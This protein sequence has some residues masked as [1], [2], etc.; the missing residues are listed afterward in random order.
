MHGSGPN[1]F[2]VFAMFAVFCWAFRG[3]RFHRRGFDEGFGGRPPQ[4]VAKQIEVA[5][6]ERDAT[7]ADLE[8]RVRVLERIATDRKSRLNEEI[9]RLRA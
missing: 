7:I 8:E 3:R 9:D 5:L 6:A 4:H 2:W 1:W